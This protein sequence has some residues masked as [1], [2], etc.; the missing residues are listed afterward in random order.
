MIQCTATDTMAYCSLS[1]FISSKMPDTM[2][3]LLSLHLLQMLDTMAL[4]L[5][6]HLLQNA[7]PPLISDALPISDALSTCKP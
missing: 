3:L 1:I 7:Y 2:A 6:L 5:S 4:L